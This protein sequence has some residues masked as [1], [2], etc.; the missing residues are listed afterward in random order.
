MSN[1]EKKLFDAIH[2]S[3]LPKNTKLLIMS[4]LSRLADIDRHAEEVR[5][6]EWER[7]SKRKSKQ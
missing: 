2:A 3:D 1:E 5:Q 7:I 4:R 6:M